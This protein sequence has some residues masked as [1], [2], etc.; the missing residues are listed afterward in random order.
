MSGIDTSLVI[1][2]L[3][4]PEAYPHPAPEMRIEHTHISVVF[5]VG[6]YAYKV[7]KPLDLG[8]LDFTTLE[9]RE[10]FCHEEVRLNRPRAPSVYLGVVPITADGDRLRIEGQG[11]V[12]EY[13][14]KME[15]L[16]PEGTLRRYLAR[17][18]VTPELITRVARRIAEL[19]GEAD[20]GPEIARFGAFEVVSGNALENFDQSESHVG[21]TVSQEVFQRLRALTEAELEKHQPLIVRRAKND[22]PRDTHGDLH[23]D[24]IY[25]QQTEAPPRDLLIV[26]CIEFN[27]RLRFSD[28]VADMGFLYMDLLFHG[29]RD[30]AELF[31]DAYFEAA[32]DPDGRSLLPLYAAY[33]AAVRGKVEGMGFFQ[34]SVSQEV[35]EGERRKARAHWLVGLAALEPPF[36]RPCLVL[37]GGLPGTGKSTLA[38]DLGSSAE[39]VAVSC[40][41]A[42]KEPVEIPAATSST[43][44]IEE[45]LSASDW[46][47]QTYRECLRRVRDLLFRGE[48]VVVDATFRDEAHRLGFVRLSEEMSVPMVILE[49]DAD[50]DRVRKWMQ[51]AQGDASDADW[52]IYRQVEEAWEPYGPETS[53]LVHK[54]Q[55]G[56]LWKAVVGRALNVLGDRGLWGEER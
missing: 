3:S 38:R 10:H 45:D 44:D 49:C 50:R 40:D 2:E 25:V 8:F 6:P 1:E 56:R 37:V 9:K 54:V 18:E 46:T 15:R 16:S 17:G 27:D 20:S 55:T 5:L 42:R 26:D 43:A 13:A 12:V 53:P 11:E 48:R 32:G 47:D 34:E 22:G 29:R 33:R 52:E 19:H 4:R 51:E 23:L 41:R 35:R 36:R 28:P 31:A 30:L 7:K 21:E 24:H 14:V 39:L